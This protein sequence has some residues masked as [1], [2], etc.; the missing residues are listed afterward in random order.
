MLN[1]QLRQKQVGCKDPVALQHQAS[2]RTADSLQQ[3]LK[4]ASLNATDATATDGDMSD[5]DSHQGSSFSDDDSF[6][7]AI[8]ND[9]TMPSVAEPPKRLSLYSVPLSK[10][11][12]PSCKLFPVDVMSLHN[13]NLNLL[14]QMRAK[15]AAESSTKKTSREGVF[16]SESTFDEL[17]KELEQWNTLYRLQRKRRASLSTTR[18]PT[19]TFMNCTEADATNHTMAL[20]NLRCERLSKSFSLNPSLLSLQTQ[21]LN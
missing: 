10:V 5:K 3:A 1:E 16:L 18:R 19:T 14:E 7:S 12:A 8:K 20:S 4:R 21:G 11:P 17:D 15:A 2:M 9:P 6:S 13:M